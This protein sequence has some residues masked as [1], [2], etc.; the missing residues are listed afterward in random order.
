MYDLNGRGEMTP[1]ERFDAFESG[2][3]MDRIP[4]C[5]IIGEAAVKLI[6]TTV[7]KF[8]HSSELMASM[9]VNLYRTFHHDS[10]GVGP[11][12]F[13]IA[14][15]MGTELTF[16]KNDIPY[17]SN[18]IVKDYK[19]LGELSP[20]NPYKD[21]RLPLFIEALKRIK[22]EVGK[23]VGVGSSVGG[24]LT[25]AASLRGTENLLRDMI[26]NPEEVHKLLQ[27]ATDSAL[28]YIDAVSALGVKPSVP[29]P[30]GSGTMISAKQFRIFVKPYLKQ[31]MD[32]I[33][34]KCGSAP[35]LH[36]C[37]NTK[38]IWSDMADTGAKVLSIDNIVD[39][40]EAKKAVGDRVT[41]MGNVDPIETMHDGSRKEIFENARKCISKAYDSPKGFILST[42]CQLPMG[43]PMENIRHLMDAAWE[44]GSFP[45]NIRRE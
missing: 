43:T 12:L 25:T 32:R 41:L 26:R 24:P 18:P 16:P 45:I 40:E 7:S 20:V 30:V 1:L 5:P 42:G 23:E 11:D 44:Y 2:K 28:N 13:S 8:C 33:K 36:I 31:Y 19:K 10:V 17:V 38:A 35:T 37:G 29:E 34:E 21:G 27:L 3:D 14:E 6:D 15:A 22:D 9:E 39:L 4:C